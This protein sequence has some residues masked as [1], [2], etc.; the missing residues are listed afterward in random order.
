MVQLTP[1]SETMSN[2][3]A[4]PSRLSAVVLVD[5]AGSSVAMNENEVAALRSVESGLDLFALKVDAGRGRVLNYTGDGALAIF[6]SVAAAINVALEFQKA[7]RSQSP[8]AGVPIGFRAG[9]H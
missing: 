6:D 3:A 2:A 4:P 9:V 1:S 8:E 7:L 5:A